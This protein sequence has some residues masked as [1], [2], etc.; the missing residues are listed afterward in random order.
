MTPDSTTAHRLDRAPANAV[1]LSED[2]GAGVGGGSDRTHGILC[3]FRATMGLAAGHCLGTRPRVVLVATTEGA[4]ELAPVLV[5]VRGAR[6][7]NEVLNSV[8]ERVAVVVVNEH[9][10]GDGA[11]DSLPFDLSPRTPSIRVAHLDHGPRLS[12]FVGVDSNLSDWGEVR[13]LPALEL[14]RGRQANS[15]EALVMAGFRAEAGPVVA[16][17]LHPDFRPALLAVLDRHGRKVIINSPMSTHG[18]GTTGIGAIRSGR[19]AILGDVSEE[20]ARI[21]AQWVREP[22]RPAPH[23]DEKRKEGQPSLFPGA[24]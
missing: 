14:R 3:Q 5:E 1:A 16:G 18:A 19:R 20:H 17:R 10:N 6:N 12:C 4:D 8:V 11:I 2:G 15:D 7:E 21:A 9:P 13:R 24:A 23:L 22:W